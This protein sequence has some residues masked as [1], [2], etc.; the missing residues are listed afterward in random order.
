MTAH[1]V[2]GN[3]FT[4]LTI[5]TTRGATLN[6][7]RADDGQVCAWIAPPGGNDGPSVQLDEADVIALVAYLSAGTPGALVSAADLAAEKA[8][9]K[10]W[11]DRYAAAHNALSSLAAAFVDATGQPAPVAVA[12]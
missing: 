9:A 6:V 12:A 5:G 3:E 7:E 8:N 2:N 1:L 10:R 11:H 4:A